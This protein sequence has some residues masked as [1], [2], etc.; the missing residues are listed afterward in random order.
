MKKPIASLTILF[1]LCA[2]HG[3][4][5]LIMFNPF[6]DSLFLDPFKIRI[7]LFSISLP[8]ILAMLRKAERSHTIGAIQVFCYCKARIAK[9]CT[10]ARLW[11]ILGVGNTSPRGFGVAGITRG[12]GSKQGSNSHFPLNGTKQL[13]EGPPLKPSQKDQHLLPGHFGEPL[14]PQHKP[15]FQRPHFSYNTQARNKDAFPISNVWFFLFFFHIQTQSEHTHF[16]CVTFASTSIKLTRKLKF[17][18][19]RRKLCASTSIQ[20]L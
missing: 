17:K 15:L 14:I 12:K 4:S 2:C 18:S 6:L 10:L 13:S 5:Q 20:Y 3:C 1:H 9:A 16:N 11:Y 8:Q 7:T 19:R